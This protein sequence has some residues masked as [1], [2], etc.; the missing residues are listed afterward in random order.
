MRK[1]IC[2]DNKCYIDRVPPNMDNQSVGE[3]SEANQLIPMVGKTGKVLK[4]K[5]RKNSIQV[6]SGRKRVS[7]RLKVKKATPPKKNTRGR[8]GRKKSVPCI[9]KRK[10]KVSKKRKIKRKKC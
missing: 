1:V 7:S 3:S 10:K 4:R 6:G 5:R 8:K 9:P 2:V